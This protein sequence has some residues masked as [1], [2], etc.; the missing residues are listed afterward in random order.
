V[1]L[2][3]DIDLDDLSYQQMLRY[4][5]KIQGASNSGQAQATHTWL[6]NPAM[7]RS[8]AAL[9]SGL[10]HLFNLDN[11]PLIPLAPFNVQT[12]VLNPCQCEGDK[13]NEELDRQA[14]EQELRRYE[15]DG[16]SDTMPL[17]AFWE[18]RMPIL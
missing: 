3:I 1:I 14:V 16:I 13:T 10:D 7:V 12:E 15:E 18:V 8:S 2:A 5:R 6:G 9:A 11:D 4:R 17:V